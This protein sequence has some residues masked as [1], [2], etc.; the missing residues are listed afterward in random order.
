GPYSYHQGNPYIKPS[1]F[2]SIN[3]SWSYKNKLVIGT[4]FSAVKKPMSYG[5]RKYDNSN[6]SIGTFLNFSEGK[7]Y[8]SNISYT[9]KLFKGK[10]VSI[11]SLNFLHSELPD[12]DS[13]IRHH[14]N[15]ALNT[16]NN[17]SLPTKISMELSAFY[18]SRLLD[19][20]VLRGD[21]YGVSLGFSKQVL[22]SKGSLKLSCTDVFNTQVF[23]NRTNGA[24][25]NINAYWKPESRFANLLFTYRFGNLNVKAN[26]N[27]TTGIEDEKNRMGIN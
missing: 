22:R 24:G 2:N 15:Y 23:H 10:W 27:R 19:G 17:I 13:Q 8:N 20:T 18:N 26:K 9:T 3:V 4:G 14:N 21:Y 11:N 16:V 6:S 5:Y 1:Y 12:F 7:L 25:I